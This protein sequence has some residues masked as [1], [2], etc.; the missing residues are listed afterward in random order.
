MQSAPDHPP[1]GVPKFALRP[2]C[3][4]AGERSARLLFA[5]RVAVDV[6]SQSCHQPQESDATRIC[7]KPSLNISES[8]C[9]WC[10]L[11]CATVKLRFMPCDCSERCRRFTWQ[12]KSSEQLLNWLNLAVPIAYVKSIKSEDRIVDI[13]V[14]CFIYSFMK[15]L[16]QQLRVAANASVYSRLEPL[17]VCNWKR[18][19]KAA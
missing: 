16:F 18:K 5:T 6:K 11:R 4:F 14:V 3:R 8:N 17:S 7:I 13:H 15:L 9:Y 1:Y 2:V 10:L 12:C 19:K